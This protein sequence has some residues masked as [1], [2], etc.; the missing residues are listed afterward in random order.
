V[1]VG[2]GPGAEEDTDKNPSGA[3]PFIGPAGRELSKI[4][5]QCGFN[6]SKDFF[7]LN[8]V[9]CRTPS[10]RSPLLTETRNCL[11]YLYRKVRIIAPTFMVC[12][13][14]TAAE[15]ILKTKID[16]INEY[17]R[18]ILTRTYPDLNRKERELKILVTY[19]PAYLLYDAGKYDERKREIV[20][21]F[22]FLGNQIFDRELRE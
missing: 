18:K 16:K 7:I 12:L 11:S 20:N 13:G 9:M 21:D 10:N 1:L 15:A 3:R 5:D 14:R 22:N 6:E 4:I 19:H 2:E 17:R 8:V